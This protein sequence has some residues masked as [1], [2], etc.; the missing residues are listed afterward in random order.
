MERLPYYVVYNNMLYSYLSLFTIRIN[1][2]CQFVYTLLLV[3]VS[4]DD[5]ARVGRGQMVAGE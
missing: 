3:W 5:V 1:L 2:G 4:Y